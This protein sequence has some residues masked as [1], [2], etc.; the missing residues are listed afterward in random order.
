M[1]PSVTDLP[2][3]VLINLEQALLAAVHSLYGFHNGRGS[4]RT[5]PL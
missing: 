3:L 4:E 5:S 1:T 2:F